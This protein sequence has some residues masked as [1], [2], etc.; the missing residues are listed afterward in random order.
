MDGPA[1]F[2]C[3]KHWDLLL[4]FL[5]LSN[6]YFRRPGSRLGSPC[7]PG[8]AW[9][10]TKAMQTLTSLS[11][12]STQAEQPLLSAWL[13]LPCFCSDFHFD[14]PLTPSFSSSTFLFM[15]SHYLLAAFCWIHELVLFPLC[16]II[17]RTQI[18]SN[19]KELDPLLRKTQ[20]L[21]SY[22]SSFLNKT[23]EI[24]ICFMA[25]FLCSPRNSLM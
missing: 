6:S 14:L 18:P 1:V 3:K 20:L 5:P 9:T 8:Q 15:N 21:S 25:H 2:S 19:C 13:T 16:F 12:I 10:P 17:C 24:P 11:D 7:T 23:S 4:P 22:L